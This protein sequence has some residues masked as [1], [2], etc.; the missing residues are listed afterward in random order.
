MRGMSK[1]VAEPRTTDSVAHMLGMGLPILVWLYSDLFSM[2]IGTGL[3][4]IIAD[5]FTELSSVQ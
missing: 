4:E 2:P 1:G 5:I 3:S